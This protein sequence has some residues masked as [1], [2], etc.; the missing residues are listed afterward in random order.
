[1]RISNIKASTLCA[2]Q[3][4]QHHLVR[5]EDDPVHW[6]HPRYRYPEPAV[7]PPP[8][9]RPYN[10][11]PDPHHAPLALATIMGQGPHPRLDE[12]ERVYDRPGECARKNASR[13]QRK[14][15]V[16]APARAVDVDVVFSPSLPEGRQ[17][18]GPRRVV[19]RSTW[20]ARGTALPQSRQALGTAPRRHGCRVCP[21][22]RAATT[23][24]TIPPWWW[25]HC[26]PF[27]RTP[28]AVRQNPQNGILPH[29][30]RRALHEESY[31][32]KN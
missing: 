25:R 10:V 26:P 4:L 20:R 9:L 24:A 16:P 21:P 12:V 5:R 29:T 30:S 17:E 2:P 32:G 19:S 6:E 23:A 8:P 27:R 31:K 3:R 11:R 13:K 28:W 18:R 14:E 1:M 22:P 7:Q 15:L